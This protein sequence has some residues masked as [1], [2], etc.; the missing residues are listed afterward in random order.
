MEPASSKKCYCTVTYSNGHLN[1]AEEN[2]WGKMHWLGRWP[3]S[4]IHPFHR[5]SSLSCTCK[6]LY[7]NNVNRTNQALLTPSPIRPKKCVASSHICLLPSPSLSFNLKLDVMENETV[8]NHS[9]TCGKVVASV[10]AASRGLVPTELP[11]LPSASQRIAVSKRIALVDEDDLEIARRTTGAQGE[12]WIVDN[13]NMQEF[14][15]G[16]WDL[17]RG[18]GGGNQFSLNEQGRCR[19]KESVID[20]DVAMTF[21][22]SGARRCRRTGPGFDAVP[23]RACRAD[24]EP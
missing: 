17:W 22:R 18:S 11:N 19:G 7:D 4:S 20:F 24:L 16:S 10:A 9:S 15:G 12:D 6:N 2:S 13:Q 23:L 3:T 14:F 5:D 1:S 8:T 21:Q